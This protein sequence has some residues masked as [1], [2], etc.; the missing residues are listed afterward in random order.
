MVINKASRLKVSKKPSD[1]ALLRHFTARTV[2]CPIH[3]TAWPAMSLNGAEVISGRP[4]FKRERLATR[5]VRV[6]RRNLLGLPFS[7][8]RRSA[9]FES[10]RPEK[11]QANPGPE[12]QRE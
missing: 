1:V 10:P 6:T 8:R 2:D 11:E 4:L 5:K 7:P 9:T 12:G 3:W